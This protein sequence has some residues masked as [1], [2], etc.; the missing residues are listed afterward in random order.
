[1]ATM[2]S[3]RA[4]CSHMFGIDAPSARAKSQCYWIQVLY[5]LYSTVQKNLLSIS[6]ES[7]LASVQQGKVLAVDPFASHVLVRTMINTKI[8]YMYMTYKLVN[9]RDM[10]ITKSKST[11]C[12]YSE[13][14]EGCRFVKAITVYILLFYLKHPALYACTVK[15]CL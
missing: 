8:L 15:V 5:S 3:T 1:M 12:V 13:L 6:F 14:D 4:P 11:I 7:T 10:D 2:K 9:V